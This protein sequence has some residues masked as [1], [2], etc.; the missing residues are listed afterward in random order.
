MLKK[1]PFLHLFL[2]ILTLF[3]TLIAGTMQ[4]GTDI[5]KEPEKIYKGLP[6]ALTLMTILLGHEFSHYF[7]SRKHNTKA[8]LPY[9]IPA[10]P[11]ISI[12]GTFGAFIKMKSPIVTRKALIDIGASGPIVG[13]IISVIVSIIGLSLS[14]VVAIREAEGALSLGDSLLFSFLSNII[15]NYQTGSQDI[16]LHPVAFAGWIGLFVTS[17]NLI[18]VGQLDGGHIAYALL[19]EKNVYLS[20]LLVVVMVFLGLLLWP[21][22][23]IWAVLLLILG[24]RHPP[25]LYWEAPLDVRRRFIGWIALVIFILTFIPVPFKIL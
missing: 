7:A 4:T 24:L 2:F 3:S 16:L 5:L 25:V 13:F 22:W 6:F 14:E 1:F 12:I 23:A 15:L 8:T 19:G 18:P 9:F 10:P 11:L 17:L 20:K 21:G